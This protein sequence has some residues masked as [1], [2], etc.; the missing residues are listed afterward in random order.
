[1]KRL[2]L[3]VLTLAAFAPATANAAVPCRDRIYNEWYH[4]GKVATSYP[5]S[6]YRDAIRHIPTDARTYSSLGDDILAAM[7]AAQA[8]LAG[9]KGVPAEVGKGLEPASVTISTPKGKG[10]RAKAPHDTSPDAHPSTM[11]SPT[12]TVSS[13]PTSG[14]SSGVPVPL[15]VL[16]GLALL[17]IAIGAA[18][19]I[20]K[21]RRT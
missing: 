3:V 5:L 7:R 2:V 9:H 6:C 4:S 18:G 10:P 17:L 8:R 15:I 12:S 14:G 13:G 21:R 1:M 19:A 20:A 16:G 11:L